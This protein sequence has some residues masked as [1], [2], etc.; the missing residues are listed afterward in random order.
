LVRTYYVK[1][2]KVV[3][4]KGITRGN[5][6]VLTEEQWRER[7][8]GL[9]KKAMWKGLILIVSMISV[10]FM[11]PIILMVATNPIDQGLEAM[12]VIMMLTLLLVFTVPFITL[13]Q[14]RRH[15]KRQPAPGLYEY[16][17]QQ[18]PVGF[19]PY[20][21]IASTERKA[22]GW[23]KKQDV[24]V[25]NPRYPRKALGFTIKTPW[26]ILIEFIGEEGAMELEARVRGDIGPHG[27]P[28][29]HIYGTYK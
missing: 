14:N 17:L 10:V 2:G 21:E 28:E 20:A 13:N 16:G 15:A 22:I 5:I 29:L 3:R 7:W 18:S 27:P 25:M 1:Q 24:V 6:L 26:N 8:D 4:D 23:P 11:I 12:V 19:I 9:L